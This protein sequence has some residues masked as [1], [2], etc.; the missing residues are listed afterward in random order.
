M[1]VSFSFS[2]LFA[3]CQW[4]F[5]CCLESVWLNCEHPCDNR[6]WEFELEVAEWFSIANERIGGV[7]LFHYTGGMESMQIFIRKEYSK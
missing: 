4:S 2:T 1:F 3:N 6:Y 7:Y 5:V